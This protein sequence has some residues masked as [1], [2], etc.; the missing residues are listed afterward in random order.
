[1]DSTAN[2]QGDGED[3]DGGEEYEVGMTQAD[4]GA[5]NGD[6]GADE[7]YGPGP[8]QMENADENLEVGAT[9][10]VAAEDDDDDDA[11]LTLENDEEEAEKVVEDEDNDD[12]P[13]T[14][15][16]AEEGGDVKED[17]MEE[18]EA[19]GDE[20]GQ[21]EGG[22]E[23]PVVD[24]GAGEPEIEVEVP[25]GD[26]DELLRELD[27]DSSDEEDF[28]LRLA[29]EVRKI[30][31]ES[32]LDDTRTKSV[33]KMLKR[34]FGSKK[35]KAHKRYAKEL[36]TNEVRNRIEQEREEEEPAEEEDYE[37]RE[38]QRR[39][40]KRSRKGE[41]RRRNKKQK[42][43][44]LKAKSA[45]L[46]FTMDKGVLDIIKEKHPGET[47]VTELMRRK[48]EMWKAASEEEKQ[49]FKEMA[50]E[51]KERYQR[52]LAEFRA[53]NPDLVEA[54]E[55]EKL[56]KKQE[57]ARK[58]REDK[59]RNGGGGRR[60]RR[61]RD[62]EEGD[63]FDEND[64]GGRARPER[65]SVPKTHTDEVF[66]RIKSENR[67]KRKKVDETQLLEDAKE[68]CRRMREACDTD[69]ANV[70]IHEPA[71][72]K[73]KMLHEVTAQLKKC[74]METDRMRERKNMFGSVRH[75]LQD[76]GFFSCI[77]DWLEIMPN[78]AL[79]HR[80][81][82]HSLY[83]ALDGIR[84][85]ADDLKDSERDS[86]GDINHNQQ[87]LAK[88]LM[89]LWSH[90]KETPEGRR[91]LGRVLQR[92]VREIADRQSNYAMLPEVE[93]RKAAQIAARRRQVR[94]AK[95][96]RKSSSHYNK[97]VIP[98]PV[99]M[100]YARRP[101]QTYV[102]EEDMVLAPLPMMLCSHNK[103]RC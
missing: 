61:R 26:Q 82:R 15:E 7:E 16:D 75:A 41:G 73:L 92:W 54:E 22:V 17:P 40:Q 97:T 12:E 50:A 34:Q 56:F 23:D 99:I 43:G 32:D 47:K 83:E 93:K 58:R 79:P 37:E 74:R 64:D 18:N 29:S 95:R 42:M 78:G 9:Q 101:Q 48:A 71:I 35:V 62:D 21:V 31:F 84:I 60:R 38:P 24:E 88:V 96:E 98:M 66:N 85:S 13:L 81:I 2:S 25:A 27:G 63:D 102:E 59:A 65:D 45:Y 76:A 20:Q 89:S 51:D 14:L 46:F 69:R 8:T 44:P 52:E 87:G 57:R 86:G 53:A 19:G 4:T 70:E 68:F 33:L 91:I 36:I 28:K 94:N 55:R 11:P 3:N 6:G 72:E 1:M 10:A 30:I 5:D 100:D 39:R 49:P 67:K 77:R 80:K 103:N 90:K